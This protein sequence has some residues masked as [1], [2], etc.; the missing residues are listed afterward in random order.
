MKRMI[1]MLLV[2][3]AMSAPAMAASV[4]NKDGDTQ[5]LVIVEDGSRMEVALEPGSTETICPSGCF[6]TLPNGDRIALN[7]GEEVEIQGGAAS[8]K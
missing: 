5:V 2:S 4:T 1:M 7:G 8:V 6:V 3:V